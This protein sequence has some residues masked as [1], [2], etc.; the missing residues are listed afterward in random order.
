MQIVFF[1]PYELIQYS[2]WDKK[3]GLDPIRKQG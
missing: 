2:Q 1:I 3:E